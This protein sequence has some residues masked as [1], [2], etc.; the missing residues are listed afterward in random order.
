V[1]EEGGKKGKGWREESDEVILLKSSR[2]IFGLV[3][4]PQLHIGT[5]GPQHPYDNVPH[6]LSGFHIRR[7][8]K[9]KQ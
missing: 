8:L 1:W 6:M 9:I 2:D 4:N 7:C 3:A 5:Q